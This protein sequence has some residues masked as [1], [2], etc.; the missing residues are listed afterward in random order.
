MG[1]TRIDHAGVVQPVALAEEAADLHRDRIALALLLKNQAGDIQ[2]E[3]LHFGGR[4]S[5]GVIQQRPHLAGGGAHPVDATV[6][7]EQP[8]HAGP[9]LLGLWGLGIVL[10]VENLAQHGRLVGIH[11]AGGDRAALVEQVQGAPHVGGSGDGVIIVHGDGYAA[12]GYAHSHARRPSG[13]GA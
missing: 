3:A 6:P 7:D 9:A 11:G 10:G 4:E 13:Q 8:V 5:A 1:R 2:R 12:N